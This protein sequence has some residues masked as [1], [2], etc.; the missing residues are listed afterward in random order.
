ML[1]VLVE[2]Q[3]AYMLKDSVKLKNIM[4]HTYPYVFFVLL[5]DVCT[6]KE[7]SELP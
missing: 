5:L 1:T 7:F 4:T 6:Y 3:L 2:V